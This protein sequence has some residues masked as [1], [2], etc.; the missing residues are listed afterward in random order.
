MSSTGP[1][2]S[3]ARPSPSR[4]CSRAA[5][6]TAIPAKP[7][8]FWS[9]QYGRRI[10]FAGIAHTGDEI[11]F[12]VGSARDASFLAVYRRGGEPVAVLGMDQPKLFTR[13]RRQLTVV[14]VPA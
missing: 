14:P 8:Y 4:P 7:P 6:T 12:E 11:T 9:D 2:R 5:G 1:A 10:Q 3:S 13:W